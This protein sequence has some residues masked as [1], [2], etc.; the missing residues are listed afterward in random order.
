MHKTQRERAISAILAVF[1]LFVFRTFG[2]S[3]PL[4][5]FE[6]ADVRPAVPLVAPYLLESARSMQTTVELMAGKASPSGEVRLRS[7]TMRLLITLA[8]KEI[9]QDQY[10]A[11]NNGNDYLKGGPGW[12]ESDR[13]DLLAKGPPNATADEQRLMIQ[14][15]LIERF[16][17]AVHRE[18]KIMPA[19]G[20]VAEKRGTKLEPARG[21]G[22]PECTTRALTP[23][24]RSL[25]CHDAT[26]AL[27]A[28]HLPFYVGQPVTDLTE[29]HGTPT[30][31]GWTL[32]Q[33]LRAKTL[34]LVP[35]C[36]KPWANWDL[37]WNHTSGPCR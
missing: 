11:A 31:F 14:A 37:N 16:H 33:G 17:L 36:S 1:C 20:L 27:L 28:A 22:D 29:I 15:V 35:R 19:Y 18:Q 25:V 7:L 10:I 30:M 3:S 23:P 26:I 21:A 5:Q 32:R 13:F 24:L 8:Y 34:R 12:L 6:V 9:I 4:P 2:Q